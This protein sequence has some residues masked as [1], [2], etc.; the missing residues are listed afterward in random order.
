MK[1]I[2][3]R[4]E[5]IAGAESIAAYA[6]HHEKQASTQFSAFFWMNIRAGR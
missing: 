2:P 1:R 4:D 3:H 5:A 6:Q